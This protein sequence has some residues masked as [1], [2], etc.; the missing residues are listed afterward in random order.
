MPLDD[1]ADEH[2]EQTNCTCLDVGEAL[3][4][5]FADQPLQPAP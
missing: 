5:R 3:S 2:N 4:L 1:T